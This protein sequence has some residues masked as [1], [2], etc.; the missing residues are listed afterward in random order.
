MTTIA[1]CTIGNAMSREQ[2]EALAE[3]MRVQL[4]S[5]V[6]PLV[7]TV[8]VGVKLEFAEVG[9]FGET[10]TSIGDGPDRNRIVL[11]SLAHATEHQM[12]GAEVH[13][14]QHEV[15][16]RYRNLT[17]AQLG[18]TPP[19]WREVPAKTSIGEFTVKLDTSMV[20]DTIREMLEPGGMYLPPAV[21]TKWAAYGMATAEE[22]VDFGAIVAK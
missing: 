20:Q 7:L 19:V 13:T 11:L 12:T 14:D 2:R 15:E 1:I 10:K 9:H 17:H 5:K 18:R 22:V 21:V 8:P 6:E 4:R 3:D 16:V